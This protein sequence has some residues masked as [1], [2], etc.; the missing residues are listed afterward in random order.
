MQPCPQLHQL[1]DPYTYVS[2]AVENFGLYSE[3]KD[4]KQG[5]I[6]W[7]SKQYND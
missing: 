7:I 5:L 1:N 2:N 3:C 4:E 6:D